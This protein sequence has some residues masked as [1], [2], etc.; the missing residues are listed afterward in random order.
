[1]SRVYWG[2]RKFLSDLCDAFM[3]KKEKKENRKK[4]KSAGV[5]VGAGL[6]M[7]YYSERMQIRLFSLLNPS[8]G[9]GD[10]H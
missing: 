10:I 5:S 4:E 1:M 7:K 6:F 9:T 3:G 8:I 2:G